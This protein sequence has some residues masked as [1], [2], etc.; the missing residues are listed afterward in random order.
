M[1]MCDKTANANTDLKSNWSIF[2]S[3]NRLQLNVLLFSTAKFHV[4]DYL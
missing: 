3:N 4:F 1:N 2:R